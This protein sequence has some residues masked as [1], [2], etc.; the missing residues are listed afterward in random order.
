MRVLGAI[1]AGGLSRRFGSDKAAALVGG[2]AMI[3]HVA[4]A[5][6]HDCDQL[7]ICGPEHGGFVTLQ[8]VPAPGLGPL[9]GLC[10]ALLH[11]EERGF[12]AVLSVPCDVPN[13][14]SGLRPTLQAGG[15]A[16][17]VED[18][19][20]I[21]L[22][23]CTLAATLLDYLATGTDRSLRA[24]AHAAGAGPVSIAGLANINT[25]EDLDT[26]MAVGS[27]KEALRDH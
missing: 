21:G 9:G 6:C 17:Y 20:V 25:P 1:L 19:P 12:D 5:L 14:P 26:F 10:A 24:W 4:E 15:S 16:S 8:D 22:W 18:L 11:G 3:D 27:R 13:L 23:P 2:R 7:V